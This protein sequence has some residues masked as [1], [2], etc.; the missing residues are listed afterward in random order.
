MA[1][2]LVALVD[3]DESVRES[4]PDLLR[5]LGYEARAFASAEAFLADAESMSRAG[6]LILDVVMP[7]ISG[8]ELHTELLRRGRSIPTLF[9]SALT[10]SILPPGPKVTSLTKP[11]SEQELRAGLAKLL[12][13][14]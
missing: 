2:V 3:D 11:F 8:P 9:I 7:G 13:G 12:P 10:G 6:C 14:N 4:L 5:E 1:A